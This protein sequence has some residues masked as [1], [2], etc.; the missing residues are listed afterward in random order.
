MSWREHIFR[1]NS[2]THLAAA[3]VAVALSVSLARGP[4]RRGFGSHGDYTM[5][6][7]SLPHPEWP[8]RYV[9]LFSPEGITR[10]PLVIFCHGVG[11]HDPRTYFGL[12][13]H[14]VSKGHA[15]AYAPF[16]K[17]EAL[18]SPGTVYRQLWGG[19][20][21][22]VEKFAS[23]L[24]TSR[25]AVVGHS[26]GAGALPFVA[27]SSL[28]EKEWGARAA[29]LLSMAPWYSYRITDRELQ[30]FPAHVNMIMQVYEHDR[31]NDHRM[32][33]DIYKA[34]GIPDS[35]KTFVMLRSDTCGPTPY[36][37][38]HSVPAGL[39]PN[40]PEVNRLDY[41]GIY[42]LYDA[43]TAWTFDN[44][45]LGRTVALGTG[46]QEQRYMGR[47]LGRGDFAELKATRNPVPLLHESYF[48]N[49][50]RHKMNPRARDE[51]RLDTT[52]SSVISS[53]RTLTTYAR[54]SWHRAI[55]EERAEDE[56]DDRREFYE[57]SLDGDYDE[58]GPCY[59]APIDSGYGAR[60]P[61]TVVESSYPNLAGDG[62]LYVAVPNTTAPRPLPVVLVAPDSKAES[63]T[64]YMQLIRHMASRGWA[65]L[66][67]SYR[68]GM[69][70]GDA[71]RYEAL[72]SGY[73]SLEEI[74]ITQLD[75][76]RIGLV[77]HGYGAATHP[78]TA[79]RYITR[80]GW[81][82]AGAFMFLM[83]PRYVYH[84]T[85]EQM[86]SFPDHV[87]LVL[88]VYGEDEDIDWRMAEDIYYTI[89]IP[90][91]EKN[92][93]IVQT[94]EHEADGCE[95]EAET[96]APQSENPYDEEDLNAIDYYAIFRIIDALGDYAFT[97]SARGRAVAIGE[98][99]EEVEVFMGVTADST[100]VTPMI[101]TDDPE[102]H[103]DDEIDYG[104]EWDDLDNQR[105]DHYDP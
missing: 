23:T 4:I 30:A 68:N 34:I 56:A 103:Y 101:A 14:I 55:V 8:G 35:Q 43:L 36:V 97:G 104:T 94:F 47:C 19:T 96:D 79:Y 59:V 82:T 51:V 72:L 57:D 2:A 69:F 77:G 62:E 3:L 100:E 95:I 81:G 24:D 40:D 105:L 25:L 76:T 66:F 1:A 16:D 87:K 85:Q 83:A 22:I 10:A 91:T 86:E 29:C 78:A 52:S 45:T 99:G 39:G 75:T 42:R 74:L 48:L 102:E 12:V 73:R 63:P 54:S 88:Q 58:R 31:V 50:Y 17:D 90:Q 64:E 46:S 18:F 89:G 5:R 49:F 7:D 20:R 44:H 21:H 26:Y 6:Q 38:H 92:Y 9:Y 11:G 41:Y 13:K 70:I 53:V 37:A 60:G 27:Y 32:A 93:L 80:R 28:T 71:W 15:V 61:Y 98:G 67:S 65:V 33:I 84:I